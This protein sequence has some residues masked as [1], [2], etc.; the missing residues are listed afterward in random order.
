MTTEVRWLTLFLDVPEAGHEAAR[1]FWSAASG[2]GLS[3]SRGDDGEFAT[4]LPPSGDAH[5]RLQRIGAWDFRV[6]LDLH[7]DHLDAAVEHAVAAGAEL[8]A[9][10]GHAVLRSPAGFVFCLVPAHGESRAAEPAEWDGHRSRPDQLAVDVAHDAWDREQRF[11]SDLTG[12]AVV[13]SSRPEFARLR[14][15]A[16]FPVRILLHRLGTG[17]TSGHL[18]LATDDRTAE[19]ERLGRLGAVAAGGGPG[20]TVM[21]GPDG[22]AFC[23]TDR[24]PDTGLPR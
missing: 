13:P 10:P 3:P 16:A 24:D 4:F 22:S 7:V 15:P 23:V 1:E 14:T 9:R 17:A 11:W 5:L 2:Y 21:T 18:D 12:W 20:W 19:V 8:I 6:H